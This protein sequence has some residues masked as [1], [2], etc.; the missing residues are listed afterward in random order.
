MKKVLLGLLLPVAV[1]AQKKSGYTIN[2]NIAGLKDSTLVFL[3]DG[4][5]GNTIAQDYA[6]KG[7][8]RLQGNVENAN[9]FQLSFIGKKE[10]I[11]LFMGNEQVT[12]TGTAAKLAAPQVTGAAL[13][14]DY[15]AYLKSFNPLK[16]RLNSLIGKVNSTQPGAVRDSLIGQINMVR[17]NVINEVN[18]FT[19]LKPASPVSAFVLYVVNP[20]L[21]GVDDLEARYNKLKPAARESVY[22]KQIQQ[23]IA[24][25]RTPKVGEIGSV[26]PDFTQPD[27]DGKPISLSS[28]KGKYVL[29]DFWASWCRPCRM[30]N[31]NVVAAYNAFKDK[32]FTVLGV[33]LDRPDGKANWLQAIKDDNLTWTHVSDLQ[34]WSNAAAQLYQ[35]QSI[36]A[37]FLID[38]NGKIVG[39]NLRGEDL[40]QRLKTLLK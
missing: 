19:A 36:P 28:F 1:L 23:V 11:E 6:F 32:N 14:P 15:A 25:A 8:F 26:A 31:P 10:I 38:P 7:R 9:I 21:E 5:N 13:Q 20:L 12:I 33:S 2:G 27:A 34:F 40:Q 17:N 30:E 39:K 24:V 35:V 3:V 37:N 4:S 18:K 29:V 22:G 16:E